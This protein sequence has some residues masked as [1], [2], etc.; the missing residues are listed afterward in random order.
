MNVL[1][2]GGS[3]TIGLP[4]VRALLTAG[5]QVTALSRST[6]RHDE[7]RGLGATVVTADAL[8]RE[9]LGAAILRAR[10]THV[11]HQL[12]ALPKRGPRSA[13][14]LEATN[15][16]RIDGTR[17]LLEASIE[18]GARRF[19][20]GSFAVLS[21][22]GGQPS[23]SSNAAAAAVQSMERQVLDAAKRGA[24][25]GLVL[26]YGLFYGRDVPSTAAM[27]AMVRKRRLP[28]VRGD[29][30]QLPIIHIDDAVTATVLALDHG[31]G[32]GTY[33]I[34]DDRAVSLAEIVS[35]IAEYS[36][37][38]KPWRVPAW[39][40]R[41]LSPYMARMMSTRLSLSNAA[42]KKE[43]GWRPLYPTLQDG[44]ATMLIQVA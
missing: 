40:I 13:S 10:P 39:L 2:A 41:L 43:L 21:G 23:T 5:H 18:A 28:V 1:V 26:R 19:I 11:I 3:G 37:S 15:R 8:D 42:A 7:L 4:L 36:A 24:I 9:A 31:A 25:E 30:G 35:A 12:T 22:R 32:G 20:A 33:D 38:P 14:D 17:N 27:I 34:V 16:L 44:V 29:A 6:T